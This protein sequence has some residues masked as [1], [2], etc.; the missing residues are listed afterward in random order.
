MDARCVFHFWKEIRE[1]DRGRIINM[2]GNHEE[3]KETKKL[4]EET[5]V[6]EATEITEKT[7]EKSPM[8]KMLYKRFKKTLEQIEQIEERIPQL[9]KEYETRAEELLKCTDKNQLRILRGYIRERRLYIKMLAE[10]RRKLIREI[11]F[12]FKMRDEQQ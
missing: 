2:A 4:T 12:L 6:T 5:E 9:T 8:D 10:T 11:Q 1:N 7:E 3:A